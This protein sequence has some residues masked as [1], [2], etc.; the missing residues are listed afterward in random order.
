M[1]SGP[2]SSDARVRHQACRTVRCHG[3]RVNAQAASNAPPGGDGNG[4]DAAG[5]EL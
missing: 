3:L 1:P 4:K 2:L 5:K